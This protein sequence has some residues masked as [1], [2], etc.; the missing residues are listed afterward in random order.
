MLKPDS[1]EIMCDKC[2][3]TVPVDNPDGMMHVLIRR[4]QSSDEP[5][6]RLGVHLCIPC[7][8]SGLPITRLIIEKTGG[9]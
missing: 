5:T 2:G 7:F 6:H 1:D 4:M 3:K 9:V 8:Y